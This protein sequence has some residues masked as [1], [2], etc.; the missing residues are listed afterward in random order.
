MIICFLF[1]SLLTWSITLIEFVTEPKFTLFAT[2]QVNKLEMRC[3]SKKYNFIQKARRLRRWQ[4]DISKSPSYW[5]LDARFF[6][7]A[8]GGKR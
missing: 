4:T 5:G 3:C 1:S 8:K 2:I 7:R 6:Y